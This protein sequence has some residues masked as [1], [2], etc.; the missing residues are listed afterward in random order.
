MERKQQKKIK[1]KAKGITLIALV[2]TIVVLLILAGVSINLVLGPNGLI[3]R[4]QEAALKTGE[5]EEI[6]ALYMAVADSQIKNLTTQDDRKKNLE[7]SIRAQFGDDVNFSVTDNGDGSFLI[8][9]NDTQR[10]YYVE[11][12]G[13]IIAQRDWI[14]IGTAEEL[15]NFRDNVNSGNTY[16]GKYIRLTNDITLDINEEWE[17]IGVYPTENSTPDA[18][19]NKPFSGTFDG[20]GYEIDGLYINTTDK[21]KG[22]FT[23][24]NNGKIL[25]L[26]IVENCNL[27]GEIGTGMI[28]SVLYNNSQI[29]NCYNKADI[30]VGSYSGGLVGVC[31]LNSIIQ[32][33][34]NLGDI[35]ISG[36]SQDVIGGICG[37]ISN[38]SQI[39]NC[40]NEGN[41]NA[42]NYVG[43]NCRKYYYF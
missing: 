8:S 26:G 10:S 35:S 28:V 2:V 34:Y 25:N 1:N 37:Q 20:C 36:N 17:P 30:T 9:M 22:L 43:R 38:D 15:K 4:A 33:C 16:A 40:Y 6:E 32:N 39:Y 19:T 7:E 11:S 31:D 18:E 5:A 21:R 24:V 12:S 14:E 42:N 41:I 13:N 23:L 29:V 3:S 27:S